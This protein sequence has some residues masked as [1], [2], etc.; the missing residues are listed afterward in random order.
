MAFLIVVIVRDGW[1][2]QE[3]MS[4]YNVKH[5]VFSNL[6]GN[7]KVSQPLND[8]ILRKLIYETF[9]TA[10]ICEKVSSSSWCVACRHVSGAGFLQTVKLEISLILLR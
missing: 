7:N 3:D 1:G 5:L 9:L 2:G 4:R 10:G 6:K 8:V